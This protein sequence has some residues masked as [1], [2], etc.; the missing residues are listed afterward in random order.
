MRYCEIINYMT[1][2]NFKESS[3]EVME[4]RDEVVLRIE[5][6]QSS[7]K[8]F[9]VMISLMDDTAKSND[10]KLQ[11]FIILRIVTDGEDYRRDTTSV[12]IAANN[13]S[14]SVTINI[15]DDDISECNESF[16]LMLSIPSSTC[17]VVRGNS[18]IAEVMIRDNDSKR[19]VIVIV[20]C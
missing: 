11:A 18:D 2:V 3:Y 6:S 17:G 4:G 15:I 7:P 12:T 9:E 14:T 19:V 10:N 13:T 5:L 20:L 1:V 8:P 16:K